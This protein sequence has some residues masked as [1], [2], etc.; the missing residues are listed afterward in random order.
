MDQCDEKN[1]VK[2][3]QG[4]AMAPCKIYPNEKVGPILEYCFIFN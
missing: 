2:L 3:D 4:N 1:N